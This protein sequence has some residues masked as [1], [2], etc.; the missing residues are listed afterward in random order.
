MFEEM[1]VR[2][3]GSIQFGLFDPEEIKRGSVVNVIYPETMESSVPKENGLIDLRMGTTERGF[4]CQT[5]GGTSY[6]CSGHYGHI[7]LAKP[8][9][10]VGYISKIKK[11]L[12]CV[13]FYCSRI[14]ISKKKLE[15]G[16]NNCW[17]L[18]KNKMVCEGEVGED[19]MT[20]CMNKQPIIK[21]EGLNLIVYMKGEDA[22]GKVILNGEKVFMILK[23]IPEDDEKFLG[24]DREFCRPEWMLLTV[25][26]VPPPCVRPSIVM[27]GFLRGEDDLTHKLA[28]IVKANGYLRKYEQEGAPGHIIRD[29][30]QLLQFHLATFIDNDIGGQPQSLQKNGRPL[31]SITARLKGKEGRLRGNLMGKRVD[32]S[33]R[34][35]ITPEP[36]I[37]CE[38]V[39][40]PVEIAKIHTFPEKVTAFNREWLS[41]LVRNGPNE[42]PGANYVVRNDGQR[43]DL[44]FNRQD[45]RLEKGFIVERHM[46]SGDR[47]LFNRQPSLHKMSMMGHR[48]R[49]MPGKTFRLNLS[50]TKPYNADFDGDEMNLHMPQTYNTAAEL[51]YLANVSHQIISPQSNTPIIGI[52]QDTLN[53]CR[54]FTS[55]DVFLRRDE[56]MNLLYSINSFGCHRETFLDYVR[57]TILSPISLWTGKHIFSAIIPNVFYSR[58]ANFKKTEIESSSKDQNEV[59][60]SNLDENDQKKNFDQNVFKETN[61]KKIEQNKKITTDFYDDMVLV[62]NGRLIKG[63]I[64]KKFVGA[65][66]LGIIQVIHNDI[67]SSAAREF[68][69]NV[70]KLIN[71]YLTF[72]S[73][74][75]IGIGDCVAD[76]AT[77]EL[78][79]AG[80]R[81]AMADVDS[82]ISSA[83]RGNLEK[84]PGMTLQESFESR[85]NVIL[86]KTRDISGTSAQNSLN[87]KNNMKAMVISGAKGSYINISQCTTC[88]GQQNVEGKRIPFG[89]CERSLPHFTKFDYSAKSRGF[90]ESSYVRGLSPSEFFF[91]AMGGREGLIDTAI[92]TAETGYIQRRL[93]K[94]MESA[95]VHHDFSVRMEDNSVLQYIYGD[96]GYSAVYL[97]NVSIPL[98]N[99]FERYC[100]STYNFNKEMTEGEDTSYN[101][102][103][104][105]DKFLMSLSDEVRELI[106]EDAELKK[107]LDAEYTYLY[108]NRHLIPNGRYASP[109]NIGRMLLKCKRDPRN[110]TVSPYLVLELL[111]TLM[112]DNIVLNYYIRL[113]LAVKRVISVCSTKDFKEIVALVAERLARARVNAN[114]MVGTLAAQSVGEP[115]TQ[116]TL[117]TFHL[118]GV[119]STVTMGVPRLNEIINVTKSIKTPL[120]KLYVRKADVKSILEVKHIQTRLEHCIMRNIC[121]VA[122]II[123]DPDIRTTVVEADKDLINAYFEFPDEDV[124]YESL[125]KLVIRLEIERS[126]LVRRDLSI[127]KV[128]DT[129]RAAFS[130]KCHVISSDE[131]DENA[132]IRIR[133]FQEASLENNADN[134]RFMSSMD[135]M[136]DFY[137]EAYHKIL[138]LSLQGVPGINKAYIVN[139]ANS[140]EKENKN[141]GSELKKEHNR[142]LESKTEQNIGFKEDNNK[143]DLNIISKSKDISKNDE[144]GDDAYYC[145]QTDGIN[146]REMMSF[147]GIDSTRVMCNDFL[148]IYEHLGIEAARQSIFNEL[149]LIIE[150]NGSYV[151]YRH[152]TLLA[153]VMTFKGYLT[154]ITRHGINKA[155]TGALKKAS[156]EETVEIFLE[157]AVNH[158]KDISHGITESIMLGQLAPLGTGNIELILDIK[159][160]SRFNFKRDD[161][162][163]IFSYIPGTATPISDSSAIPWTPQVHSGVNYSDSPGVFSPLHITNYSSDILNSN[164]VFSPT[165]PNYVPQSPSYVHPNVSYS[166]VSPS[167]SPASPSYSPAS[168]SYSPVSPSYSPAS[169]SYSPAS[170]SYSP[171]SPSYSPV[172][173]SYSPVSPSYSPVSPSYSPVSPSYSPVSPSYSPDKSKYLSTSP[174]YPDLNNN[175]NSN[176]NFDTSSSNSE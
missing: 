118:A 116:M 25:L 57:P 45:L 107:A 23:K 114:E 33:A 128:T 1:S 28:D 145:L 69:D 165:S 6:E 163:T 161:D 117:N 160:L 92:K 158:V 5:C 68:I 66:A 55:K 79:R 141:K 59:K 170:P 20:G 48:A 60:N 38:E 136:L 30:E 3:I 142:S 17:E 29:Y 70:Q 103:N 26:L 83:N 125:A 137:M 63:V 153:D 102:D 113:S 168:P 97:E 86:N 82:V 169:P 46:L 49:V 174:S 115:A 24:F 176:N 16:L 43:I 119:A 124:A 100:I 146:F 36:N 148:V 155:Q 134:E 96:D 143:S 139:F 54:L 21:K 93:V 91:H 9:F 127:E 37:S 72:I 56:A 47:V 126:D 77:L 71:H 65:Q 138:D 67:G 175:A 18:L 157:A 154:G 132:C 121:K 35:V 166:P 74:F 64:D 144:D 31:K 173:P 58:A 99:F 8:M 22:D 95:T 151:N 89:F 51:A 130:G 149:K 129:V 84:Q 13:C 4:V 140:V 147:P 152:L 41:R 2:K 135:A 32:F 108:N 53:G 87:D 81:D 44:N 50:V 40:V 7:E 104:K 73:T 98:D 111:D 159:K 106:L 12:E 61:N 15:P 171:V 88:L 109:V 11:T 162:T 34:T 133:F 110:D 39:G 112:G 80:I 131:N 90:V 105:N 52:V 101:G 94:A 122:Q 150:D 85:V 19:G 156:F 42:Y 172:S 167:Y 76:V 14:K 75:S 123:Y 27:N 120:M 78:C 62:R 164:S 10:H